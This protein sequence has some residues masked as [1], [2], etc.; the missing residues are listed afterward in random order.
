MFDNLFQPIKIGSEEIKNRFVVSAMDTKLGTRDHHLTERAYLYYSERAIGGFGLIITEYLCVSPEGLSGKNQAGIFDDS[1]IPTLSMLTENVHREG[2]KIFA[3]LQHGGRTCSSKVTNLPVVGASVIPSRSIKEVT[4]ELTT[5]EVYEVIDK[6][7][8]AA[9]RAK[10]AGFDG[11]EIHAAHGYLLSQFLS[12]SSNK[13]NDEF[14]G[15]ITNRSRMVCMIINKIKSQCGSDF[16]VIVKI[17]SEEPEIEGNSIDESKAIAVALEVA[18]A[19]AIDVSIDNPVRSNYET[20]GFNME[21]AKKIRECLQIPV[22]CLGRINDPFLANTV[23]SS[24]SGDLVALGR[25]SICDSHF[26]IKVKENRIDEI[27]TCT[28]CT[29]RCH[30]RSTFEHPDDGISC[31]INPLSGKESIWKIKKVKNSKRILIIGA[32]PAGLQCGWILAKKG[33]KV[34]IIEA[35]MKPG[36]QYNLLCIPPMKHDYSKTIQTYTTLCKKYGAKIIYQVYANEDTIRAYN[37]DIVIAA[38]GSD[39]II[40]KIKGIDGPNVVTVRDVLTGEVILSGKRIL[41]VGMGLVG[42]ETADYLTGFKNKVE[43][44]GMEEKPIPNVPGNARKDIISRF[45]AKDITLHT[46]STILEFYFDGVAYENGGETKVMTGFDNIV[47]ALG[48]K[49]NNTIYE[50]SSS[51]KLETYSIGDALK[52]GDAKKA[53]YEATKLAIEL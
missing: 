21:N 51:M 36:G 48:S 25:Q 44:I 28:G 24:G 35:G 17:N 15:N 20:A 53:I 10:T 1:F 4:H 7:T 27:F 49:S 34:T 46:G 3:Q 2:G 6:F 42:I 14:G 8:A 18:G 19:D 45:I 26:P 37:P 23:L 39:P 47:L 33:H 41:V 52:A 9:I 29:Q 11:I 31:M 43:I 12:K 13:R 5:D 38:N 22:I 40:P 30:E 32:G 50:L 16:P